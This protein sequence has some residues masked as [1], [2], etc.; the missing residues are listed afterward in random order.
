MRYLQQK[1]ISNPS[2]ESNSSVRD[3]IMLESKTN[4]KGDLFNQRVN[5]VFHALGFHNPSFNTHKAGREIDIALT[6]R[7]EKRVALVESKAQNA[8]ISGSDINKFVGALD[9][10]RLRYEREGARV[11]GYFVSQSGFTESALEQERER[12]EYWNSQGRAQELILLGPAEISRELIHG[13]V[14]CPLEKAVCAVQLPKNMQL[15]LCP[16]ADLLAC[17]SGWVWVLY[18]S[19]FSRQPATHFAFVHADGNPLLSSVANELISKSKQVNSPFSDLTYIDITAG[20]PDE[21]N[22][23]RNAYYKYLE[24]ELGEIQFEGM[25]TDKE[26]GAVKVNLENIF[27]PLSFNRENKKEKARRKDTDTVTVSISDVLSQSARAAILARPGG[28]K[29]TLIRRMALA[30]AYFERKRKVDGLAIILRISIQTCIFR[31]PS[32]GLLNYG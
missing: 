2:A 25:P 10:E 11:V 3:I 1:A 18:Y 23:A 21:K 14:L 19:Q 8:K 6:H 30:Y 26:A 28:G 22:D 7:T 31:I 9:V 17:E 5:D 27:V 32:T 24:S 20:N 16:H 29:S 13:N 12:S 4:Q 15:E